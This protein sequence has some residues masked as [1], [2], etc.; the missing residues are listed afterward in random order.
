MIEIT[1][2]GMYADTSPSSVSMIGSAVSEPPVFGDL[3]ELV[4]GELLQVVLLGVLLVQRA[5]R[6]PCPHR[7]TSPLRVVALLTPQSSLTLAS[8]GFVGTMTQRSASL[9]ERSSKREWQ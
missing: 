2:V 9:A 6:R 7:R 3:G 1:F 4:A 8:V 5:R